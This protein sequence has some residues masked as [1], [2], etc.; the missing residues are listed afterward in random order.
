MKLRRGNTDRIGRA[1]KF[2]SRRAPSQKSSR[3]KP[4]PVPENANEHLQDRTEEIAALAKRHRHLI[5]E[6]EKFPLKSY[7]RHLEADF[8]TV[9]R[10]LAARVEAG[11]KGT[12]SEEWLLDNR[13]VVQ[14]ALE[15]VR[16]SVPPKYLKQ[17]PKI[18]GENENT[19]LR[20]WSLATALVGE[21]RQPLDLE[22]VHHLVDQYQEE[23]ILTTGELWALPAALRL[24]LLQKLADCAEE[25][26][27]TI[28]QQEE[29]ESV[30]IASAI[31]SLRELRTYDWRHFVES[32][33]RV[34]RILETDP[35]GAYI[36]MDFAT[37]DQYRGVIE[38]LARGSDTAEHRIAQRVVELS[39][40]ET[41]DSRRRHIGYYLIAEGRPSLD[42]AV[43]F[44]PDFQRRVQQKVLHN[45][46]TVYFSTLAFFSIPL[47][48]ALAVFLLVSDVSIVLTLLAVAI[49]AVPVVGIALSL[50]NG[51][52]THSLHPHK[53]PKMDF[54]HGIPDACRTAV[55]MPVLF[56]DCDDVE[57]ILQCLEMNYLN[58]DDQQLAYVIL[59]DFADA[60]SQAVSGDEALLQFLTDAVDALNQ[61][62]SV[63]GGRQPF[64]LLHRER[65]WNAAEKCWMGWERKRGKLVEFNRLLKGHEDHSFTTQV[66]DFDQ[67]KGVHFVITLDA[68]SH[69]PPATAARLIAT[70]AHP[71]NRLVIDTEGRRV[72]AGHG[73][74]QPRL[75]IDP[76]GAEET[77]FS[78]IFSGDRTVDLYTHAVSDAYQDLFGEGIFAGKGIYDPRVFSQTL[79]GHLP[80]NTILSHDLLEGAVGGAALIS[81]A[82]F[83][84]QY[85]PN[86]LALL[87]R[88]HRWIRGDWQLL[89]WLRKRVTLDSGEKVANPLPVIQRW[90]I[91]DNLRRSLEAPALLALFVVA[92][93]GLLPGS[94]LVWTLGLLLVSAVPVWSELLSILWQTLADLRRAPLRLRSAPAVLQQRVLHWLMS[95]AILPVQALNA[96]DAIIRT[97]FRLG[98]SRRHLLQWTSA[99]Q[100]N[101][102]VSTGLPSSRRW[103][104]LWIAPALAIGLIVWLIW[105]EPASLLAA[106]PFLIAWLLLP[107]L[108]RHIDQPRS[109][110][111]QQLGGGD[112]RDL[113]LLARRT[114]YFF[115]HFMG[116]DD[117]WL[118]PDNYQ[119]E[120]VAV[121]ARR[122]SPTNI[123][124][125]ILSNL[126]AYDFG[127]LDLTQLLARLNNT[128][129]RMRGLE[130]YRGHFLNWYE[131]RELHPLNPRYVSTV[132]SGNLAGSLLTLASGLENLDTAPLNGRQL[133]LG[134][135]DTLGVVGETLQSTNPEATPT[136]VREITAQITLLRERLEIRADEDSWWEIIDDIYE[137]D[138]P[139]L[140]ER[141]LA[142]I[143]RDESFSA[144]SLGRLRH[145][146]DELHQH[147]V[148][149]R[150]Y[151]ENLEPWLRL[152]KAPPVACREQGSQAAESFRALAQ[153]LDGPITLKTLEQTCARAAQQLQ[154]LN[155]DLAA[156]SEAQRSSAEAWSKRLGTALMI[157][158][159]N[160]VIYRK[161]LHRLAARARE[162]VHEMD[163]AF[164]YDSQRHLFHIGYNVNDASL[165]ANY[166]DL[167]ASESRLTGFIAVAKGDV[168][169]QHWQYLERPFR[170]IRRRVV[171]MSWSATLFEYLMPRL[172]METPD[173]SLIGRAC[174]SA[175]EV[176][177][178]F[179][180]RFGVP[181]GIA[182]SGF[183]ELD[184]HLHYQYR[185]F[186]VP[187]IGF[188]RDLGERLVIAPYA[189]MMAL[190][191]CAD[192]VIENLGQIRSHGGYGQFGLHEAI[193]FGR[194]AK[195]APRRA[196]T[197]RSYMSH[198]QGMI[199]LAINNFL[200]DDV[201]LQRFHSDVR[202][203]GLTPLLH[204]RLP[205]A[206]PALK[207]WKRPGVVRTF[208]AEVVL[209]T[210]NAEPA[211]AYPQYN[212][213]ANGHYSLV[214]AAD[215]AGGS[216]WDN[217]ALTRWQPDPT[218]H[219][220]GRFCYVRDLDDD[221][222]FSVGLAPCG[223]DANRCTASFSPQGVELQ[224]R[225]AEL[226]CRLHIAVSSQHDV[227]ARRLVIKNESNR[228]RHLLLADFAEV[229]LAPEREDLRHPAFA[230]LF[231]ESQ[232]LPEEQVM[233][234][235][236]R[237]RGSN[238][239]PI[240]MAV[241]VLV[242][243]DVRHHLGWETDRTRFL[244]RGGSPVRPQAMAAGLSGFTGM[245][246]PVLDPVIAAAQEVRVPPQ[247]EIEVVYL[248]GVSKSRQ[249]LLAT[250]RAYR[251]RPKAR[252][253]FDLARMQTEQELHNLHITAGAMRWMME[254]LSVVLA[255]LGGLRAP[256]RVL[257]QSH[258][259]QPGLWSRG[260][261]GDNPILLVHITSEQE[262][263][264]AESILQAHTYWCGRGIAVDLVIIDEESAGYEQQTRD[265]LQ[266]MILD[267]R[268]RTLRKLSG[269]VVM[270]PGQ[271]LPG[272]ERMRLLSAARAILSSSAGTVAQQLQGAATLQAQQQALP[273][274]VPVPHGDGNPHQ[275]P[276]L[277]RPDD[278]LFDNGLG[279][280]SADGR[281]Y[282]LHLQ[283]GQRPP[284]PWVNVIANPTFGCL[285]SEG[286]SCCT[287]S[288][289][290]GE[291]RLTAWNNDPVRDPSGE[292][293]YLRDEE[294]AEVWTP[295]PAPR[296]ADAPYQVRHG[297]GYSEFRHN[298]HGLEQA[299]R[300]YTDRDAPV[301]F[302]RL[303]LR[304]CSENPRRLT[305]TYYVEWIQ[306]LVRAGSW[307][308]LVNEFDSEHSALLAR[309]AF[310]PDAQP[311]IAF[312]TASLPPHGLTTDRHE[313]LGN[314]VSLEAPEALFRIGLSGR[315]QCGGDPCA[316]Y[317]VHIDLGAGETQH[318]YFVMGEGEDRA[319]ALALA[320]E[321]RNPERAES[322]RA[323]FEEF[324]EEYLGRVQVEVPDKATELMVNRWL[325]YQTLACRLWGRSG[326]YQ[327]SGAFGFRDQLQDVQALLW[328]Q[329]EWTREH[330]LRAASRQFQDG[331]VLH[332]W[333]ENPLRGVRTR[334]SDDLLWLPFVTAQYIR[335]TGDYDILHE[336]V[337]YLRGA[338]LQKDEHERYAEFHTSDES[339]SLYEHCC[340]A[341]ERASAVGPHGLPVIGNGDWN[342]GFSRISTTGRGESV[343]MGWFLL[344][345]CRDMSPLC[346]YIGDTGLAEYYRALGEN[347]R[348]QVEESGWDGAWYRRAYYDDGT[349]VGSRE[350]D[351]CKIDLIAQAWSVLS[352]EAPTDRARQAM[353]SA[354]EH[355]VQEDAR[356]VL[357]L[358]PAFDKTKKDPGYIKGYPPGI[359]ENGGQYTHA[360]TWSV[361]AAGGLEHCERAHHLFSLINPITHTDTPEGV[362]RYRTE[363]YVLAGDV[364]G[365]PPHVGR[366]GWTWYSGASG[367]LYR[368]AMEV[369]LGAKI[370]NGDRLAI[371]PCLP[372]SWQTYKLSLAF[373][374]SRYD[375]EVVNCGGSPRE[376]AELTLNGER[377]GETYLPLKDDGQ[378][379]TVR[380][381][382]KAVEVAGEE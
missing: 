75:E 366:G 167:L 37:R 305:A 107:K 319:Q 296:P 334:C 327:S 354:Y 79:A 104:A 62:Y 18:A 291:H 325:P 140:H 308:Y 101:R 257:A 348:N 339:G 178:E 46:S 12:R 24:S 36:D 179:A 96:L 233:I 53:L 112:K 282:V 129:D 136:E 85:P 269:A 288:G 114:W 195:P 342:D 246:G 210:W 230:K 297:A 357:L 40:Q 54:Q 80:E 374:R 175:I 315:V 255:P 30:G 15:V 264:F 340:R 254:L 256:S 45:A 333:H 148:A 336:P 364:Y 292:V 27:K 119:E 294:T 369:L 219:Q 123:G 212:L 128:F 313:F 131:T 51:L 309:N 293:L 227:E 181:W 300:F 184:S 322:A 117:H 331:D 90:K 23:T 274:F 185:A 174:R 360:A 133:V 125:G 194:T 310:V 168:P 87:K 262:I 132:D 216:Y 154:G 38:Q 162:W 271:E 78:E 258:H 56:A 193:D 252:W 48:I 171:L 110:E 287:W 180:D 226:F 158:Q 311:G 270:V 332:W 137:R 155:A 76:A 161:D 358:K 371:E 302:A 163:F 21:V 304:N 55:V 229:V 70:M 261:S 285:V 32:L 11:E 25:S 6:R 328:T 105:S 197:V 378:H 273:P 377:V 323:D 106:G 281:E 265:R 86:L 250:L 34:E 20:V 232:Y 244:G 172:M 207:P 192:K 150:R 239:K 111:N 268:G 349:P 278:L 238:E 81:D 203:A 245:T 214:V 289:N 356:Q 13:H 201:M 301:K 73:F 147:A 2:F 121:L 187:G 189:S 95:L 47:L 329:P 314:A 113:R 22:S 215:G 138:V 279:G 63:E 237:P 338:P 217:I 151:Q 98:I 344:R 31:I 337:S 156:V 41:D 198:H 152:M 242:Q 235:R 67:L 89:P 375:V 83:Y 135:A 92:W 299:L 228:E 211:R 247:S 231:V 61:R 324:W 355:L 77:V 350:S 306:G 196:R 182:E 363:P 241:S 372:T 220:W 74:L 94:P 260:I 65:N 93:C 173:H 28:A 91:L 160:A 69:M 115:E 199:L 165:D 307:P 225:E 102:S 127:Y 145:W 351:E 370:L 88:S 243:A 236:R 206:P 10:Q 100:V 280:F 120:P 122:T 276:A 170:R 373:K 166:Y 52:I 49:A 116:P 7:L 221:V 316:A 223:G 191:F 149:A 277:Q 361:W 33:S 109:F 251:S 44:K 275:T 240:Y 159:E 205:A 218:L 39:D 126:S 5:S 359:R 118:P 153:I 66:G 318:I 99:A 26:L 202:I 346:E 380:W 222:L 208:H 190:P 290:S 284:A 82:V 17:L 29:P 321:F 298:S 341:I 330:I 103:R 60:E 312:L 19:D 267:I 143:E 224:R 124:L 177:R 209:D 365:V 367:W 35:A 286:G 335:T 283:P 58:N 249:E 84:E 42:A 381:V 213:L 144:E 362:Q 317:Q 9:Y 97:L 59:S 4:T 379:H 326:F 169:A 345:V 368:G 266:E 72:I 146:L 3:H 253:V 14:E 64:L 320:G 183:Y 200:H 8:Q 295:T 43:N 141:V 68:D 204:E 343:W 108:I 176:H 382:F 130:R 157:A 139:A 164:L 188:R 353:A 186:G 50:V 142:L 1:R 303:T 347:F 259:I 376:I 352:Q 272:E 134:I 248:T 263:D 234:Y 71:L 57:R 16:E